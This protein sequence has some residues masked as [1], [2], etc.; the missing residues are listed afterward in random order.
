M[1]INFKCVI[2][3]SIYQKCIP[4]IQNLLVNISLI[5]FISTVCERIEHGGD[6]TLHDGD[7]G[8]GLAAQ[9]RAHVRGDVN[10]TLRHIIEANVCGTHVDGAL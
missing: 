7:D 8:A 5:S 9:L 2:N 4:P 3:T 6:Q 10:E 1:M